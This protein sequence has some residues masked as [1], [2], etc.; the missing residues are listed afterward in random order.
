M[1]QPIKTDLSA[2]FGVALALTSTGALV[3]TLKDLVTGIE[4]QIMACI[5][6]VALQGCLYLFSHHD[7]Y[8]IR[9]FSCLLL[10]LSVVFSTWYL[11]ST[12]QTRQTEMAQQ[13]QQLNHQGWQTEQQQQTIND[14]N[15][16]INILLASA[17]TD[18]DTGYR[19]RGLKTLE[20][21]DN[22]KQ[23]RQKLSEALHTQQQTTVVQPSIFEQNNTI[24]LSL[25]GLIALL[26][27]I[28]AILALKPAHSSIQKVTTD[29]DSPQKPKQEQSALLNQPTDE[30]QTVLMAI[31]QGEVAPAKNQV[32]KQMNIG[33]TKVANYFKR[34][35]SEGILRQDDRGLYQLAS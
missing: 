17:K 27:D 14:L 32:R 8:R 18:I 20:T 22:L 16:Q 25:F 19:D 4:A 12:W 28:T 3:L 31:V 7:H 29:P 24:R 11:E 2:L 13:T 35:V 1:R 21:V 9:C 5:A 26:I 33:S 34:M 10:I 23:Q 6:G 15:L 30:Y